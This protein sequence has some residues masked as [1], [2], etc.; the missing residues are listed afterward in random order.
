MNNS[1]S[2]S[3]NGVDKLVRNNYSCWKLCMEAYL[4][5]QDLWDLISGAEAVI[6]ENTPQNTELR[7]KWKIKCGKALFSLRTS[8]NKEYIE[9]I[10]DVASSKKVWETLERLVT[11]KNTMRLRF[12]EN[13]FAGLAQGNLSISEYFLSVKNLCLEISVLDMEQPISDAYLRHCIIRGLRNE[14]LPFISSIQGWAIQPSIIDLENL[15]S[16]WKAIWKIYFQ[17]GKL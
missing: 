10:R 5:G 11:Q 8:I 15:L 7:R 4:Q 12:L 3:Q 2:V 13:D 16:N 14:F 17:T 9:H 6:P 1:N